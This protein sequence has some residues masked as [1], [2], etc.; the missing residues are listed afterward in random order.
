MTAMS[1]TVDLVIFGGTGDLSRRKLL[2]ALY[3]LHRHGL[4]DRLQR[5]V[6]TG[7]TALDTESFRSEAHGN[8]QEFLP[9]DHWDA[10]VWERFRDSLHYVPL[11]ADESQDYS[12]LAST[13]DEG[14]AQVRLYY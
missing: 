4:A 7:R 1:Q 13:L 8:L 3:Q 12:A 5:I 10:A 11:D 14:G 9:A 6:A 2:P